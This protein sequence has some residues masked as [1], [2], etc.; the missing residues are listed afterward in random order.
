MATGLER[1]RMSYE[2]WRVTHGGLAFV[3]VFV[4]LAHSLQVG[5][6]V[7]GIGK[8]AVWLIGAGVAWGLLFHAQGV[9]PWR[10]V[11]ERFDLV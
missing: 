4:G 1:L 11:S 9:S 3:V 10:L 8:Q 7:A 2:W 5:H 6:Y